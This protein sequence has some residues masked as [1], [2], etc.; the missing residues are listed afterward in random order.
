MKK[1]LVAQQRQADTALKRRSWMKP[2]RSATDWS[3]DAG[4]KKENRLSEAQLWSETVFNKDEM[5]DVTICTK[6]HSYKGVA[7]R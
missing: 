3:S 5:I 4:L 2:E 1:L 6:G 7:T